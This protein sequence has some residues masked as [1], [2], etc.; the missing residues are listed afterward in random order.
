MSKSEPTRVEQVCQA[1]LADTP[2]RSEP[3]L[4]LKE[5]ISVYQSVLKQ[6]PKRPLV[7]IILL[8][9]SAA[10][11]FSSVSRLRLVVREQRRLT[12]ADFSDTVVDARIYGDQ[13]DHSLVN[14]IKEERRNLPVL[15]AIGILSFTLMMSVGLG[16]AQNLND[17]IANPQGFP[18]VGAALNAMNVVASLIVTSATLF[19]SIFLVFAVTQNVEM[20]K[21]DFLFREGIIFK[22]HRDDL[23]IGQVALASLFLGILNIIILTMP[24]SFGNTLSIGGFLLTINKLSLY[25]PVLISLS[26][27]GLSTC[28]ISV[29]YYFQRNLQ[30]SATQKAEHLLDVLEKQPNDHTPIDEPLKIPGE[31]PKTISPDPPIKAV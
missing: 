22:Y 11:Q 26:L 12:R 10:I 13:L 18:L 27:V 20:L 3:V 1:L 30:V 23:F 2:T 8:G 16:L 6:T 9:K 28:F 24:F 31:N 17:Y 29:L 21:D 4:S 19:L 5:F 25:S 7:N 14:Q 15:L